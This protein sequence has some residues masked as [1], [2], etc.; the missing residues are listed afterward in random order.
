MKYYLVLL[1]LIVSGGNA[2]VWPVSKSSSVDMPQSS[3]FGPRLMEWDLNKP[4]FHRGIDIVIPNRTPLYAV[5]ASTVVLAGDYDF[6]PDR[7]VQI[8]ISIGTDTVYVNYMHMNA[9]SVTVGQTLAQGDLVGY[10]G[11]YIPSN[12]AHLHLEF[13]RND[14]YQKDCVNPWRYYFCSTDAMPCTVSSVV[15]HNQTG[16]LNFTITC[17]PHDFVF[18]GFKLNI[19]ANT[20]TIADIDFNLERI[21]LDYSGDDIDLDRVSWPTSLY[22]PRKWDHDVYFYPHVFNHYSSEAVYDVSVEGVGMGGVCGDVHV[23]I[24]LYGIEPEPHHVGTYRI[25]T[26]QCSDHDDSSDSVMLCVSSVFVVLLLLL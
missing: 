1:F 14:I 26:V 25:D 10:S 11:I 17:P 22:T 13:R 4:Q 12:F 8:M 5:A 2:L 3:P 9:T 21:N 19:T 23:N 15:Y 24:A 16:R 6:Y 18:N 20:S 7:I